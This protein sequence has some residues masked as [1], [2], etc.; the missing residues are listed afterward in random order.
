VGPWNFFFPENGSSLYRFEPLKLFFGKD[1][2]L[3]SS[4]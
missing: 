1:E 2:N 4:L 3:L